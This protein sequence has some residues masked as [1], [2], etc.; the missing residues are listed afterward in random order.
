MALLQT[1]DRKYQVAIQPCLENPLHLYFSHL[2]RSFFYTSQSFVYLY[3]LPSS[4]SQL[5]ISTDDSVIVTLSIANMLIFLLQ[6]LYATCMP[7]AS[8]HYTYVMDKVSL[9]PAKTSCPPGIWIPSSLTYSLTF[10]QLSHPTPRLFHT[11][12]FSFSTESVLWTNTP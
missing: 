6:N 10:L 12:T 8:T 4:H 5:I 9:L 11:V 2:P 1:Y 3:Y 7:T